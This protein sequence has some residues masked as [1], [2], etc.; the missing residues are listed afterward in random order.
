MS[1]IVTYGVLPSSWAWTSRSGNMTL[2]LPWGSLERSDAVDPHQVGQGPLPHRVA[3]EDED[4]LPR[5]DEAGVQELA[6]DDV[7]DVFEA[8][9]LEL[10]HEGAHAPDELE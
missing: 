10:G 6:L 7:D 3:H 2:S 5:L 1:R 9:H 4:P 8:P